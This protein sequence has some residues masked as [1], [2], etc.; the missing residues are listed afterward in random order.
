[1]TLDDLHQPT[2]L[3]DSV[4]CGW[5]TTWLDLLVIGT[6]NEGGVL[7]NVIYL[8]YDVLEALIKYSEKRGA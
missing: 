8:E 1:M 2:Y 5:L 6:C 3:G 7:Q 4:Y